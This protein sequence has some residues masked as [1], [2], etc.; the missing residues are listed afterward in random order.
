MQGT[1][2]HTEV[3]IDNNEITVD[4]C[5]TNANQENTEQYKNNKT[6]DYYTSQKMVLYG[7]ILFVI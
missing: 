1:Y 5:Y 6:T 2:K 4:I 3:A 7:D